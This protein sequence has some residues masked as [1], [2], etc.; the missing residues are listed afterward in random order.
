[1]YVTKYFLY[2][3]IYKN[4]NEQHFATKYAYLFHVKIAVQPIST[5][6]LNKI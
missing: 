5:A 2:P 4:I 1:M 3:V 6:T